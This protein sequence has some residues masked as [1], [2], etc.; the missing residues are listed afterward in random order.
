MANKEWAVVVDDLNSA[1]ETSATNRSG[2]GSNAIIVTNDTWSFKAPLKKVA[3]TDTKAI[4][5]H[6]EDN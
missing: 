4:I 3:Q 6:G 5:L 1:I 2:G